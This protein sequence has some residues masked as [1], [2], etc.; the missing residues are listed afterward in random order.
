MAT[1]KNTVTRITSSLEC[2]HA[3][4]GVFEPF[5]DRCAHQHCISRRVIVA[6]NHTWLGTRR[7]IG[8]HHT[9]SCRGCNASRRRFLCFTVFKCLSFPRH[10]W[11]M[12]ASQHTRR[13]FCRAKPSKPL[14]LGW[15]RCSTK[16]ITTINRSGASPL[17]S[18]PD[19]N[20]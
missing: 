1:W 14:R 20:P 13:F 15:I 18:T 17:Q 10:V 9:S 5:P 8:G 2:A 19:L 16:P 4:S 7:L 6:T 11:H 12:S 3:S